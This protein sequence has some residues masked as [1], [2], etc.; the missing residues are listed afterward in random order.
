M[1]FHTDTHT[2]A[3]T[4]GKQSAI[5]PGGTLSRQGYPLTA[6]WRPEIRSRRESQVRRMIESLTPP[7]DC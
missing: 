7:Y 5:R 4:C 2:H 1:R 3:H 6:A